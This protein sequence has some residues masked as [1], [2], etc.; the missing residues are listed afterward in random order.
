M[1]IAIIGMG[2]VGKAIGPQWV[3]SGHLVTFCVRNPDDSEKRA[4]AEAARAAIGSVDAAQHSDVV[5][6]AVPWHDVADVLQAAGDLSGKVLLDC[7]NPVNADFTELTLGHDTSAAEEILRMVPRAH[8]VK[9]FN[10]NGAKNMADSD[11]GTHK[12]SMFYAGDDERAN[13]IA[14]QL[15]QEIGF[16]PV[17]LGPLKFARLLEPLA[18]TWIMLARHCGFGRDFALDAIRRPVK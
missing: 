16:E 2:N 13:Q 3:Q 8:V 4:F 9:I 15:A 18:M 1:K 5:L 17:E 7:T 6:L 12:V 11:Y 14:A 10:T